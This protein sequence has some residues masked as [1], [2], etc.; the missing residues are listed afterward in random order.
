MSAAPPPNPRLGFKLLLGCVALL[1]A[2]AAVFF[3]S[4]PTARVVAVWRGKAVDARPGS[5][6]VAAQSELELKTEVSGRLIKS[7]LDEGVHFRKGEFMAQFDT[8]DVNLDIEAAQNDL[9]ALVRTHAVGTKTTLDF[10][11]ASDDLRN[12]ER[13]FKLGQISETEISVARR[14]VKAIQQE[15]DLENA[16]YEISRKAKELLVKEK[17]RAKEK[18]TINAYTDGVVSEVYAR[19]GALVPAQFTVAKVIST[20]RTVEGLISQEDFAGVA[21]G[22][23]ATVIFTGN[24]KKYDAVVSKVLPTADPAT[25]RYEVY[26]DVKIPLAELTPG[27]TGE[28]SIVV[29]THADALLVPR[30]A[31]I[32]NTL[33]VVNDGRVEAR[34]VTH[35]FVGVNQVEITDGV[36]EGDRVIVEEIDRFHEG[37]RVRTELTKD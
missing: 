10:E 7:A 8:G 28:V 23:V 1:A 21:P 18:M 16:N 22:D 32:G 11:T 20:A 12:K 25:Q 19:E 36:K 35:G 30:R 15:L 27:L 17:E 26:L 4:R 33:F 29:D 13:L 34:T 2:A 24:P 6:Q 3:L 9:D 14:G 37:D 31:L 5:V